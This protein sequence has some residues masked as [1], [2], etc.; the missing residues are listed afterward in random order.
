[1]TKTLKMCYFEWFYAFFPNFLT[2]FINW[3]VD[4]GQ[5]GK[6]VLYSKLRK[7]TDAVFKMKTIRS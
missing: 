3:N 7:K 5:Q 1:M 6:I 4:M 2:D